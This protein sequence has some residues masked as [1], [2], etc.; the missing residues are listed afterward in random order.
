MKTILGS[1]TFADQVD[2]QGAKQMLNTYTELITGVSS[3]KAP[4]NFGATD[5]LPC[6][7]VD[8]ATTSAF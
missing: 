2:Q 7:I 1:M 3:Q 8:S 6:A 5:H 4:F